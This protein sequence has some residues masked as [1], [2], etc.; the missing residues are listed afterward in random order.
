MKAAR[1]V[2]DNRLFLLPLSAECPHLHVIK[3]LG[4][5]LT[6][7]CGALAVP[8][9]GV[10]GRVGDDGQ[11]QRGECRRA[12]RDGGRRPSRAPAAGAVLVHLPRRALCHSARQPLG[13]MMP[14][15]G[16]QC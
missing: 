7:A 5:I 12:G 11:E 10:A 1:H 3:A 2:Y 13:R 15:S 16:M 6:T 4:C 14:W 8:V 9:G